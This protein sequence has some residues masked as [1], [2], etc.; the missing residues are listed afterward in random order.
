M[1]LHHASSGEVVNLA[2]L[3]DNFQEARTSALVKTDSF[4]A[5]R[6]VI[7][8]GGQMPPHQVAQKFTLHCLEGRVR[9][10]LPNGS[11]ELAA[12]QWVY[13]DEDVVHSVEGLEDASLLLTIMLP[14]S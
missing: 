4:E 10:G 3:G 7:P 1:A 6:L 2:P 11:V 8:A 12:N 13:F 14:R 5:I 9:I